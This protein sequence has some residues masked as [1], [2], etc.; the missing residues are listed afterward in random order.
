MVAIFDSN[1]LILYV[2][3]LKVGISSLNSC[4]LSQNDMTIFTIVLKNNSFTNYSLK[5]ILLYILVNSTQN[6]DIIIKNNVTKGRQ[7]VT[8][9][10]IIIHAGVLLCSTIIYKY[11][12]FVITFLRLILNDYKA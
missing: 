1:N 10:F 2:I 8:I 12:Y 4:S 7:N 11:Q 9:K 5:Y 6:R 3:I